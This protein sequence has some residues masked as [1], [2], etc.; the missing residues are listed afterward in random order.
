MIGKICYTDWSVCGTSETMFVLWHAL[1]VINRQ[2]LGSPIKTICSS[3][4][5]HVHVL[6]AISQL[7]NLTRHTTR[8]FFASL[9]TIYFNDDELKFTQLETFLTL[10]RTIFRELNYF[11]SLQSTWGRIL[12]RN[13]DKSHKNFPPPCYSQ[14]PLLTDFT[15]P[16]WAKVVWN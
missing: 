16:P 1:S 13:W 7:R 9:Q 15:H 14:S 8:K 4:E 12:G 11:H 2:N 10:S 3:I 6:Y 5:L